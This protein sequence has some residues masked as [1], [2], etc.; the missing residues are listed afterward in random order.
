MTL[1]SKITEIIQANQE[2]S[3]AAWEILLMLENKGLSIFGN[4]FLEHDDDYEPGCSYFGIT[5]TVAQAEEPAKAAFSV[6]SKLEEIG[7]SLSGNGWLDDDEEA[8]AFFEAEDGE[9]D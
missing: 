4:G 6:L 8:L 3:K 7:L 2:P 5:E 9:E 1:R